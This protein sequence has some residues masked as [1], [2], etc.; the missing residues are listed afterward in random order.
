MSDDTVRRETV[1][2]SPAPFDPPLGE[3][4]EAAPPPTAPAAPGSAPH[5]PPLAPLAVAALVCGLLGLAPAAIVLGH[6]GFV[7]AGRS[8]QRGRGLAV[9]GF[10]LGYLVIVLAVVAWLVWSAFVGDLR[11][12]GYLPA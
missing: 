9:A 7:Q 2:P 3:P 5:R 12:G 8:G 11:D 6:V 4:S 10:V 1:D